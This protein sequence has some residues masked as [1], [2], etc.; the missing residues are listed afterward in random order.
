MY[1]NLYIG[2][3]DAL[4]VAYPSMADDESTIYH[5]HIMDIVL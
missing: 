1:N 5:R 3:P 2:S 4:V